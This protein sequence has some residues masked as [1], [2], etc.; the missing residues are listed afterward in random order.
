MTERQFSIQAL[1]PPLP[2]IEN[3][4]L[5]FIMTL[6]PLS[7]PSLLRNHM[8]PKDVVLRSWKNTIQQPRRLSNASMLVQDPVKRANKRHFQIVGVVSLNVKRDVADAAQ[9]DHVNDLDACIPC[10][11]D[12]YHERHPSGSV[13]PMTISRIAQLGPC[14]QVKAPLAGP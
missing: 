8:H 6:P 3:E 5:D 10:K 2:S 7:D 1:P 9:Q 13:V 14:F 4:V 11:G 12:T